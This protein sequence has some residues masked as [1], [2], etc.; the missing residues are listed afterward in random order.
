MRRP[1]ALSWDIPR[2]V[3]KKV[4]NLRRLLQAPT[5]FRKILALATARQFW[6]SRGIS[7]RIRRVNAPGR[8]SLLDFVGSP[9]WLSLARHR[10]PDIGNRQDRDRYY[11]NDE[12]EVSRF[13]GSCADV[14]HNWSDQHQ[15]MQEDHN[16]PFWRIF[17]SLFHVTCHQ[18][19]VGSMGTLVGEKAPEFRTTYDP[20]GY[21]KCRSFTSR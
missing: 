10:T 19:L 21:N 11:K 12:R 2:Y 3:P 7:R 13:L 1:V 20:L 9:A 8:E 17:D 15:H 5:V 4:R 16:D 14:I 18:H 6:S